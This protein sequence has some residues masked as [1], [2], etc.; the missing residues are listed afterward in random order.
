[1]ALWETAAGPTTLPYGT[2]E[3]R[4]LVA[5]YPDALLV[6]DANDD[7]PGPAPTSSAR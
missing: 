7:E 3:V 1:M 5:R 6:A 2:D 4:R